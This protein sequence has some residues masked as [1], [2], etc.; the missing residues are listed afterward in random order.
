M[1]SL[2]R[3]DRHQQPSVAAQASRVRITARISAQAHDAIIELQRR[4]RRKTGKAL[5]LWEILDT[6]VLDY[7]KEKGL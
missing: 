1:T 6:A 3:S 7:A 5:R 4:H 2:F